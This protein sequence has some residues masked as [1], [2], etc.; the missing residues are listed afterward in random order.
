M[1]YVEKPVLLSYVEEKA[2]LKTY[3][4]VGVKPLWNQ[5]RECPVKGSRS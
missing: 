4:I 5:A 2:L 3:I 1:V